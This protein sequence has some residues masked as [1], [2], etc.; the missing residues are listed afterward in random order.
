MIKEKKILHKNKRKHKNN[1]KDKSKSNEKNIRKS[2]PKKYRDIKK[3]TKKL[4]LHDKNTHKLLNRKLK[5]YL[6]SYLNKNIN[7][8]DKKK[9]YKYLTK[10]YKAMGG[11]R[12]KEHFE[13]KSMDDIDYSQF[14]LN[15]PA[16]INWGVMGGPPPNPDCCIM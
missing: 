9:I 6:N 7:D 4:N 1:S 12:S 8:N 2:N 14:Q 16:D 5:K 10:K 15:I 13:I 11:A 3:K